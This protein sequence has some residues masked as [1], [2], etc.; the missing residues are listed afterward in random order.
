MTTPAEQS[1][2]YPSTGAKPRPN[3]RPQPVA[4]SN[5]P[6]RIGRAYA[7]ADVAEAVL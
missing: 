7:A 3:P 2:G 5:L 6:R 4:I 1:R